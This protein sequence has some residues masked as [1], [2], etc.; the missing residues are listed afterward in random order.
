MSITKQ[1]VAYIKKK[2]L[3][4]RTSMD[5]STKT[6]WYP[7]L[8]RNTFVKFLNYNFSETLVCPF[9]GNYYKTAN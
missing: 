7:N 6:L 9:L 5:Q 1:I 4:E 8:M 2:T 3:I